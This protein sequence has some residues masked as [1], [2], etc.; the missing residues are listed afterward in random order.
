[1]AQQ[2]GIT[3]NRQHYGLA[4]LAGAAAAAILSVTP[5]LSFLNI[6]FF[7]WIWVGGAIAV[8]IVQNKTKTVEVGEGAVIGAI[9]GL[10]AGL[11][12]FLLFSCLATLGAIVV[13]PDASH[14]E[15]EE[16][17]I[18]CAI[19]LASS[20][21][22]SLFVYPLL[23]AGGGAIG[24]MIVSADPAAVAGTPGTPPTPAELAA[25]AARR[26][27]AMRIGGAGCAVMILAASCCCCSGG[28]LF[29]LEELDAEDT[30]GSAEVVSVPIVSGQPGELVIPASSEPPRYAI[31]LVGDGPLPPGLDVG[32]RRGCDTYGEVYMRT[33]STYRGPDASHPEWMFLDFEYLDRNRVAT[34]RH[35]ITLSQPVPGARLV[36]TRLTRPS[37]WVDF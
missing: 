33:I 6:F 34:C 16:L 36:V 8:A 30:A 35:E 9:T 12:M 27:Q 10:V 21:G 11:M 7:F 4:V 15:E 3:R 14:R 20:C 23:G 26:G 1:M 28:Y 31:W 18:F 22:M 29:H 17:L 13:L 32:G 19:A 25:Q 2:H 24:A 37:D 5:I